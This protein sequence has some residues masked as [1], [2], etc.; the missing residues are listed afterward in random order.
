MLFYGVE[1]IT[2]FIEERFDEQSGYQPEEWED[3]TRALV[4]EW[5]EQGMGGWIDRALL[6]RHQ[7]ILKA[8][9]RW[10]GVGEP[11]PDDDLTNWENQ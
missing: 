1:D 2:K 11:P 6:R 10:A 7:E 5:Q 3:A 4:R 8:S 9:A